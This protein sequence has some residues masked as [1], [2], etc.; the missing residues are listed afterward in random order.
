LCRDL[1][2]DPNV[3]WSKELIAKS[4]TDYIKNYY[5]DLVKFLLESN[6]KF[7]ISSIGCFVVCVANSLVPF[8]QG[9]LHLLCKSWELN[10]SFVSCMNIVFSAFSVA[11]VRVEFR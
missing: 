9:A 6:K 3:V 7:L 11:V 5:I 4:M 1:P 10:T 8:Q 2:D